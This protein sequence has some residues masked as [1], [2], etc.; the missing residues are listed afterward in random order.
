V[1]DAAK[2]ASLL[3]PRTAFIG[4]VMASGCLTPACW[5]GVHF[6]ASSW[7]FASLRWA[8]S[9]NRKV[10][11]AVVYAYYFFDLLLAGTVV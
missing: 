3:I 6:L 2:A 1:D 10:G 5:A 9:L 7:A 4:T 8:H 11:S